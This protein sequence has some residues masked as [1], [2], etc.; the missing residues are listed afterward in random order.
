MVGSAKFLWPVDEH[1]KLGTIFLLVDHYAESPRRMWEHGLHFFGGTRLS[2]GI[3]KVTRN[4]LV[5][6]ERDLRAYIARNNGDKSAFAIPKNH[7]DSK[8]VFVVHGHDEGMEQAVA[9]FLEKLGLEPIILH[10][11]SNKG[12]TIIEKL[13]DNSD[14]GFAIVLMSPDDEGRKK[15]GELESRPRQNVIFEAGWFMGNL[16]RN[17][18]IV[19]KRDSFEMPSDLDGLLYEPYDKATGA[20]RQKVIQ[21]LNAAGYNVSMP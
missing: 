16:G 13:E 19:L 18:T 14:V 11:Q 2:L 7:A 20:W 9:R 1:E 6:F 21:E 3:Q 17:R 5:P 4:I 10:E 15:D 12:A 8:K